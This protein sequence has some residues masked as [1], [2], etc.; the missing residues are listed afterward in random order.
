MKIS[1][2]TTDE[3]LD[4]LCEITPYV[5][6]ILSDE[7]LLEELKNKV[8]DGKKLTRAEVYAYGIE[9]INSLVKILLKKRRDDVYGILGALN[10]V[11]K[12]EIAKQNFITTGNQIREVIKDKELM[13]F[14]KSFVAGEGNE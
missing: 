7:E 14:F 4:V 10:N 11:P 6:N 13:D 1:N 2:L 3:A 8:E 5:E 12:E 9:K